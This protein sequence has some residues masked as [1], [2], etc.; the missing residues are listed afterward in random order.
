MP[1][2]SLQLADQVKQSLEDKQQLNIVG[3]DSKSFYGN[4]PKGNALE[5]SGHEGIVDY[6]ASELV[7][8]ARAGTSINAISSALDEHNQR[9]SFD[10]PQ[11]AG[12]GSIGGTLACHL[13]GPGR[14]WL[15]S[16]RDMVLGL[17]LINGLG[18]HLRF[19][20][21][22]MKNVAGYDV[23][24][25]QAGAMGCLGVITEV[26]LKVLP[27]PAASV[28]VRAKVA[29]GAEA[30]NTMNSLAKTNAPITGA[31][32]LDG[33][34]YVRFEGAKQAVDNAGIKVKTTVAPLADSDSV[35][36]EDNS[37]FWQ[38]LRD[39]E[40]SFFERSKPL[41]RFSLGSSV[42]HFLSDG[43]W[44]IDWGGAQRW[45]LGQY[46]W[47]QLMDQLDPKQGQVTLFRNGDSSLD[48]FQQPA[49]PIKKLYQRLKL[50]FDPHGIF[51]PGRLYDW[52]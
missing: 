45:L 27:K 2:I 37:D 16:V 26:S 36:L 29:T 19:G 34:L 50:A 47:E 12:K 52:M 31:A 14:P 40:L 25:L 42:D 1:D 24:R 22:V 46:S 6:Q 51:N 39:H 3:H 5:I 21:Q 7:I 23:S 18:E 8:T 4:S 44:L 15:G 17:R 33:L 43:H 28:T 11:Y 35:Y 10:P 13:S 49:D 41:W 32:W 38:Y 30:I 9:L 20:G 48:C